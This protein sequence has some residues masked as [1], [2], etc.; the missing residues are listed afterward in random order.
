MGAEEGLPVA[1]EA[2]GHDGFPAGWE[3]DRPDGWDGAE[4][5]LPDGCEGAEVAWPDCELPGWGTAAQ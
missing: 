5:G 4:A 1:C 2:G 3:V